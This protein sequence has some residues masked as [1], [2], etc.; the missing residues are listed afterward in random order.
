MSIKINEDFTINCRNFIKMKT[1]YI[2][3]NA[4]LVKKYLLYRK[5]TSTFNVMLE[6][7]L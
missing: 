7:K 6:N 5:N 4:V 3:Q 2:E 1:M